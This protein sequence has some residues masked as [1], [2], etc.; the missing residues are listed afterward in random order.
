MVALQEETGTIRKVASNTW[1]PAPVHSKKPSSVHH[2]ASCK[3]CMPTNT[4]SSRIWMAT[5]WERIYSCHDKRKTCPLL[6]IAFGEMWMTDVP[7]GRLNSIAQIFAIVVK[8]IVI[9]WN[10]LF[11]QRMK[12]MK[13]GM[14]N[15][16]E[17]ILV[18]VSIC[19]QHDSYMLL[20][21][22]RYDFFI[23]I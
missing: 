7:A 14:M 23:L 8:M 5:E 20:V 3:C 22:H 2:L 6:C 13:L 11:F 15:F 9:T 16:I 12:K 19:H 18:P 4:Q 21:V 10:N 17:L 1:G